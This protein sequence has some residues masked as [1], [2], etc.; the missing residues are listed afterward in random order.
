FYIDGSGRVWTDGDISRRTAWVESTSDRVVGV[1]LVQSPSTVI[2]DTA[3]GIGRGANGLDPRPPR[4][5]GRMV[6]QNDVT[7]ETNSTKGFD[8]DGLY[9]ITL[10][11]DD[12]TNTSGW[13]IV[14]RA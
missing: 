9:S 6:W 2:M 11:F 14:S 13:F 10:T 7:E 4:E 3:G 1:R 5:D 12:G 8:F